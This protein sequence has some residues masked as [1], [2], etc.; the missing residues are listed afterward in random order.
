MRFSPL[1]LISVYGSGVG[2]PAE[3]MDRYAYLHGL[4]ASYLHPVGDLP[5]DETGNFGLPRCREP[6]QLLV[7]QI[8]LKWVE[9]GTQKWLRLLCSRRVYQFMD[10]LHNFSSSS[11][12]SF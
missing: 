10:L 1:P 3:A 8:D 5:D 6:G 11:F 9:V 7:I 2:E 12:E 4:R